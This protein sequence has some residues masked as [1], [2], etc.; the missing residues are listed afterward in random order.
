MACVVLSERFRR[1]LDELLA[2][3]DGEP[4]PLERESRLGFDHEAPV[5]NVDLER[6][7]VEIKRSAPLQPGNDALK[8]ETG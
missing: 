4:D 1:E 7:V 5:R 3:L 6:G 2:G 8:H